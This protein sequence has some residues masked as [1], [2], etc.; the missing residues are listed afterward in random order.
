MLPLDR[1]VLLPDLP[2]LWGLSGL[3]LR[4]FPLCLPVPWG[5]WLLYFRG[6]PLDLQS[7]LLLWDPWGLLSRPVLLSLSA[8]WLRMLPLD[9]WDLSGLSGLSG[10]TLLW[11]LWGRSIPNSSCH[12]SS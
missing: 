4:H 6:L 3:W 12:G 7:R 8:L 2:G 5:R 10:Q 11:D 1:W 9:L